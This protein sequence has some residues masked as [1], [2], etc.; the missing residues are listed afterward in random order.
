MTNVVSIAKMA[1]DL[2]GASPRKKKKSAESASSPPAK[3]KK[4]AELA[5]SSP[6]K[7]KKPAESSSSPAKK[8]NIA[9]PVKKKSTSAMKVMKRP[10][11]PAMKKP[12]MAKKPSAVEED[13]AEDDDDDDDEED[14]HELRDICKARAFNKLWDQL[15]EAVQDM[16]TAMKGKEGTRDKMSKLVNQAIVKN[17]KGNYAVVTDLAKLP[18]YKEWRRYSDDRYFD[19]FARGPCDAVSYGTCFKNICLC[20]LFVL[21]LQHKKTT[22]T[23]KQKN[24]DVICLFYF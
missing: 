18:V 5:S 13:D 16:A 21:F 22:I 17:K 14:D 7:K 24:V 12:A 15:P 23:N 11:A 6:A 4:P 9:A 1:A 2:D 20:H 19:E 10:S 3:K 8:K